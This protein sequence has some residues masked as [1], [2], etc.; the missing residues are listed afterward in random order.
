MQTMTTASTATAMKT[1]WHL[2]AVG[3]LSTL[4]NAFG[5][6]DYVMT[7]TK[8][9]SYLAQFTA[10]QRAYFDSYPAWADATWAFGVWGALAGS[11]FLLLRKRFAVIAFVVSLA[12]L[13]L[14]TIYQNFVSPVD[15][16][17][18]MPPEA[19]YINVAI[20]AIAI[21]LLVYAWWLR[22]KAILR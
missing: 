20:W 11:L 10:E 9:E 8:N 13:F 18:I 6:F 19:Y 12:G 22:N 17:K 4:W 2:W 5:C 21:L 15:A 1:L 3:V 14:S 7:Q 16:S